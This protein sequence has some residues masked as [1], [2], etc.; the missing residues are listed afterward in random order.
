MSAF[1]TILTISE[2]MNARTITATELNQS[3]LDVNKWLVQNIMKTC[4]N[5]TNKALGAEVELAGQYVDAL[6]SKNAQ[7]LR[8]VFADVKF[9]AA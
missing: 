4:I 7:K 1:K 9:W 2:K 5:T 8:E 6:K 3:V